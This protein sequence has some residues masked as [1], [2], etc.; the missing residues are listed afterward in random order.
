MNSNKYQY[1]YSLVIYWYRILYTQNLYHRTN[2]VN[3]FCIV[4]HITTGWFYDH[5]ALNDMEDQCIVMST[6]FYHGKPS[7]NV[8]Q[9]ISVFYICPWVCQMLQS[10]SKSNA[11]Y[12]NWF[13]YYMSNVAVGM[14]VKCIY[15]T[16]DL[17]FKC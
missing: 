12:D 10:I 14:Y 6:G 2:I 15:V 17:Y 11:K 5:V 16:I 13:A 7:A 1:M 3:T 8:I 4:H 9:I